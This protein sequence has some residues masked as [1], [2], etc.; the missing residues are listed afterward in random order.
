MHE[1]SGFWLSP[2]QKFAWRVEEA[3]GHPARTLGL[4]SLK[5]GVDATRL[6]SA[7]VCSRLT[8][9]TLACMRGTGR[10]NATMPTPPVVVAC[11]HC[12]EGSVR[13]YAPSGEA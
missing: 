13:L 5:G 11:L 3:I 8:A 7:S 9:T 1:Q 2:Q 6:K 10:T 12:P 4:V